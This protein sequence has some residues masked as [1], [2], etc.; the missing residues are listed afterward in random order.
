M[1]R[2]QLVAPLPAGV[3]L[4]R[5]I[6]PAAQMPNVITATNGAWLLD[7]AGGLLWLASADDPQAIRAAAM[8]AGGHAMLVRA[9]AETRAIV[10][11]LHPQ[12]N[13]LAALEERV[14]RAFDPA[15][16]FETGRF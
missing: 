3:P 4:W 10:P 13:M 16:V 8:Q 9:D 14:R 6:A 12:P 15:G 11:A 2:V 7:W 1:C 5:I